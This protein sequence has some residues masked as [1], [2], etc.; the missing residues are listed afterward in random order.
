M[1]FLT[2][3]FLFL[4]IV[5][6]KWEQNRREFGDDI[7]FKTDQIKKFKTQKDE[8]LDFYKNNQETY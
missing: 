7:G 6:K 4:K 2:P 8:K 5:Y 3:F 1:F